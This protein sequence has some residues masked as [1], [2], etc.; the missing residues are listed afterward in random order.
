[1]IGNANILVKIREMK[2]SLTP[3]EQKV[4]NSILEDPG[5]IPQMSIKMLSKKSRTSEASVLRFC[6]T[7]GYTGFR[8]FI[9][10]ITSALAINTEDKAYTDL[11]PG[12]ERSEIIQ[13]IAKSNVQSIE[14]TISVLD[15]HEVEKAVD[16][17][18][19]ARRIYF[20]GIGASN[21]VCEDAAHKFLRIN[22][23]CFTWEDNHQQLAMATLLTP[24]DTV[25]LI[26]NSGNTKEIVDILDVA[27]KQKAATIAITRYSKSILAENS[28]IVLYISTPEISIRS[29]AMGSRI[30]MLTVIDI[31][32][33]CV[34]S[35]EYDNI[36]GYLKKTR[37]VIQE[38]ERR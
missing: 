14:D 19:K 18:K 36:R 8:E 24:E 11:R 27:K 34:A 30:A 16:S 38:K 22:M 25:I 10:S 5:E 33:S 13:K 12:D 3:V 4:A 29:G 9:V 6:K 35:E 7:I 31:L 28:G 26:S 37:D 20:F 23:E 2:D 32:F 1:M 15:I 17:I 21:L